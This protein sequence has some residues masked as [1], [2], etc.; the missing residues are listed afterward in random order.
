MTHGIE[1]SLSDEAIVGLL[2]L[3]ATIDWSQPRDTTTQFLLNRGWSPTRRGIRLMHPEGLSASVTGASDT[4]AI[5]QAHTVWAPDTDTTSTESA[6]RIAHV[7]SVVRDHLGADPQAGRLDTGLF[8]AQWVLQNQTSVLV[9]NRS[10]SYK[11]PTLTAAET[12]RIEA[13]HKWAEYLGK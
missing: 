3:A 12:F 10:I 7:I 2:D 4:L 8:A 6:H 9:D 5:N 13:P 11:S 1:K